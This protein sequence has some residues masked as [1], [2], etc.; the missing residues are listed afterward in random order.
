MNGFERVE[1]G[2]IIVKVNLVG[3]I[4]VNTIHYKLG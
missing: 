2:Q 4:N 3:D 1:Y